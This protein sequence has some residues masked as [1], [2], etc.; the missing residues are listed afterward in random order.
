MRVGPAIVLLR[1]IVGGC[2]RGPGHASVGEPIIS[3]LASGESR[4]WNARTAAPIAT[5]TPASND[6]RDRPAWIQVSPD[7]HPIAAA[8]SAAL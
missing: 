1:T 4:V 5:L 6:A 7:G 3:T 8:A 2:G